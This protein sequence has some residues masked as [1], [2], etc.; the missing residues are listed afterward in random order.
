MNRGSFY[1]FFLS[2]T[3]FFSSVVFSVDHHT[4]RTTKRREFYQTQKGQKK[5]LGLKKIVLPARYPLFYRLVENMKL[6]KTTNTNFHAGHLY[7]H[8]MWTAQVVD[9]WFEQHAAHPEDPSGNW[10]DGIDESYRKKLVLAAFLHDVG[11]AS[12][13][14]ANYTIGKLGYFDTS[15]P[16]LDA[17]PYFNVI[18][19]HPQDGFEMV[20]PEA[21]GDAESPEDFFM[22]TPIT[23][24]KNTGRSALQKKSI[25]TITSAN[26]MRG[27][28]IGLEDVFHELGLSDNDRRF[29]AILIG[30]HWSFGV[31]VVS[32]YDPVN[33]PEKT[34]AAYEIFLQ[35]LSELAVKA[36]YNNGYVDDL[37]L[38][39]AI[40]IGAADV[41]GSSVIHNYDDFINRYD[42]FSYNRE[43][44]EKPS[45]HG[46]LTCV[47]MFDKF[48]FPTKGLDARAGLIAYFQEKYSARGYRI[49]EQAI[50]SIREEQQRFAHRNDPQASRKKRPR[51]LRKS[52]HNA[53]VS[54][55][56]IK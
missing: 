7:E 10:V 43:L 28:R 18:V 45:V 49:S 5:V 4:L 8:C 52:P 56:Y 1:T 27:P 44:F 41:K 22:S 25:G 19:S 55:Y 20:M 47:P 40:L 34:D 36:E 13:C 12:N 23:Y 15:G 17:Y 2:I 46:Q 38:R 37:L 21:D 30:I 51:P 50:A 6:Y 3:L 48:K 31:P 29:I 14:H 9:D 54:N 53:S 35:R 39:C 33:N 24:Y 32:D 16:I 42:W 11:K 26:L